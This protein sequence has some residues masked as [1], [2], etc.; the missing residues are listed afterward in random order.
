MKQ[1]TVRNIGPDVVV[2]LEKM[3]REEGLSLNQAA[4]KLLRQGAGVFSGRKLPRIGNSL[5]KFIGTMTREDEMEFLEATKS[6][7]EIDPE[8]WN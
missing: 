5:D 2:V 6:T 7:R 1:L 4:L 8:L 3:V